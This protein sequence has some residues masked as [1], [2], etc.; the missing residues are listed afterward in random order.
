MVKKF[1]F[2]FLLIFL[3]AC[4]PENSV[5]VTPA[6]QTRAPG[7]TA[8]LATA[9]SLP[10]PAPFG[11]EISHNGLAMRIQTA[12]LNA[13]YSTE[14][15]TTR[16]APSGNLFLWVQLSLKSTDTE[17][18]KL[19]EMEH[20][21]ALFAGEEFKP[22]YGHRED[23]PDYTSLTGLLFPGSPETACLRFDLPESAGLA[24]IQ[25]AF[26]PETTKVTV[27]RTD[28][29]ASYYDH[30]IFLWRLADQ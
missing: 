13:S 21:S 18:T 23:C 29:E 19:P 12:E 25:F 26:L 5:L 8:L 17:G 28:H 3:A 6:A 27:L 22:T 20:F 24:Q 11:H 30:P 9:K 1:S 14:Y 10:T 4:A 15:G 16:D 7:A 2:F